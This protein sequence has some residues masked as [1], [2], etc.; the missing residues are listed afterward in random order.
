VGNSSSLYIWDSRD[1]D[2]K[3]KTSHAG[4]PVVLIVEGVGEHTIARY[5]RSAIF[6]VSTAGANAL[7]SYA[8]RALVIGKLIRR[9]QGLILGLRSS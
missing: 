8:S 1:E 5:A 6:N 7:P 4:R 2:F 3:P 9:I